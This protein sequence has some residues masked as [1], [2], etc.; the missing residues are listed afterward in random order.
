MRCEAV[1]TSTSFLVENILPVKITAQPVA[2]SANQGD[3]VR[4]AVTTT[5]R[6]AATYQWR[7]GGVAIPGATLNVLTLHGL[8]PA[9]AESYDVIAT[10]IVGPVTSTAAS[11]T[12]TPRAGNLFG[13]G[14]SQSGSLGD[15]STLGNLTKVALPLW[16]AGSAQRLLKVAAQ[17]Q[18]TLVLAASGAVYGMGSNYAATLGIA[19]NA[20]SY[21]VPELVLDN[22]RQLAVA[23]NN[24][25]FLRRDGSLWGTGV[26]ADG[27]VG[28]F[29]PGAGSVVPFVLV[30][31]VTDIVGVWAGGGG[32]DGGC[33]FLRRNGELFLLGG[34]TDYEPRRLA[35][36][37]VEAAQGDG[38][39]FWIT[40]EGAL[41]A[42][43]DNTFGQLGTGNTQAATKPTVVAQNVARVVAGPS[44]TFFITN[45]GALWAM[46]RNTF[47][48]LG[49]GTTNTA[50]ATPVKVASGVT[51]VAAGARHAAFIKADGTMW[52]MGSNYYGQLGDGSME[53]RLS[54]VKVADNVV[55]LAAGDYYST[56]LAGVSP[57]IE[58]QPVG[59]AAVA[60][61]SVSLSVAA[62]GSPY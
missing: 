34:P 18:H 20:S 44:F 31:G 43:G 39:R 50:V 22:V 45:D 15:L 56:F 35:T 9:D 24:S 29:Y 19:S 58:I 28:E 57:R 6:P 26:T 48:Q 36:N 25:Y 49:L 37:V 41:W 2:V 3:S 21:A 62:S 14:L 51:H 61:E 42:E 13:A 47:G 23:D 40:T 55:A 59:R 16:S 32:G 38:F 46:G 7:K 52:A 12:V 27:M 17:G 1:S 8:V 60:G 10:N 4:F 54:P 11:L 30:P 53:T 33:L 5:G